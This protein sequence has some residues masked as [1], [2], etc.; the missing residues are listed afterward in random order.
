MSF[1]AI[2]FKR[3]GSFRK[4]LESGPVALKNTPG[5]DVYLLVV[6]HLEIVLDWCQDKRRFAV[7]QHDDPAGAFRLPRNRREIPVCVSAAYQ[8]SAPCSRVLRR[9][10]HGDFCAERRNGDEKN[11]GGN[12]F[13]SLRRRT[14]PPAGDSGLPIE[15]FPRIAFARLPSRNLIRPECRQGRQ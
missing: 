6:R 15:G 7:L 3:C 9:L 13:Q 11:N 2:D 10:F 5:G 14:S 12:R 8:L 1:F 4:L